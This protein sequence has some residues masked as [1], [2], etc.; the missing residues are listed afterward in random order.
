MFGLYPKVFYGDRKGQKT[1]FKP[2][3]P[4]CIWDNDQAFDPFH[5]RAACDWNRKELIPFTSASNCKFCPVMTGTRRDRG[6]LSLTGL[7]E[8]ALNPKHGDCK[9]FSFHTV[10]RCAGT[11]S[12]GTPEAAAWAAGQGRLCRALRNVS[13]QTMTFCLHSPAS[14][15]E[16]IFS[17][18]F[19][20]CLKFLNYLCPC[21]SKDRQRHLSLHAEWPTFIP[22]ISHLYGFLK[23]SCLVPAGQ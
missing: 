22:H 12:C 19:K 5:R 17:V 20:S 11:C 1:I 6:C 8:A 21:C 2:A 14:C 18:K 3:L 10:G 16:H 15:R 9:V 4:P 7:W 13:V 23:A